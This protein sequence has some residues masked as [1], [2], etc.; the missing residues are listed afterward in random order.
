MDLFVDPLV[1]H[2]VYRKSWEK[3]TDR[4]AYFPE[5]R[6]CLVYRDLPDPKRPAGTPRRAPSG[7]NSYPKASEGWIVHGG[8]NPQVV[9][10]RQGSG[11]PFERETTD[12]FDPSCGSLSVWE[13]DL[14]A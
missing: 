10:A 2:Q 11:E 14:L 6:I 5:L 3:D 9:V 4:P 1:S 8:A 7:I 12:T 13:A